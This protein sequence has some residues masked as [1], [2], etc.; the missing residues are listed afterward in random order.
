M[1]LLT[2]LFLAPIIGALVIVFLPK[3]EHKL[4]KSV[5]AVATFVSLALSLYVYFS[6]D[7]QAGGLQFREFIPWIPDFGVNY[8]LGVDGISLPMVLLTALIGFSAV[9]ASWNYEKR[10]KEF[11]ILLLILIAGVMGT[12]VTQDLFIFFLF[13]EVVVIP[14]YIMVIIWGSTKRVTK[15]YA[16]MKLTIYLLIGS[17]FLLGGLIYMLVEAHNLTGGKWVFEISELAKLNFTPEFQRVAFLLMALGFTSLLSMWPFH[18]WSPDGYAGAPT[19]VSMI[20]AG[21]LKKIGGYGLIRIGLFIMPEG[22][23]YWA[24]VIIALAVVNVA[25]AALI[26][27]AQKDLK[28]VVGYSS[29]SHMGYVLLGVASLNIIGIN[30][31]IA[32]MF[33]HGVMSALFFSMIG[34]VY[35]KTHVRTMPDL[36]GLAH[37]IPKIA[38]GFMMAGMASLGLPGLV[39]FVPEFTIFIGV[40]KAAQG[41][42]TVMAGAVI[43]IAG[44][45]ITAL[46]S[47]RLLANTLFGPRRSEYDW[48]PDAKGPELVPL[49]VL[50][51]VLI[52]G[53]LFPFLLMDMVNNGVAPLVAQISDVIGAATKMG[54]NF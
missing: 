6:Y 7:K 24:P 3:D 48:L 15:E 53:G 25:Y 39:S 11:F 27:L 51:S 47:L 34:Y 44:V 8:S 54:G 52:I 18:S 2:A 43:A 29:V 40:W 21:V 14:I 38:T 49:Y 22:A 4:I 17:A 20:H 23:K 9:Y 33:A 42:S 12:F 45:I 30:G 46:Y 1:G 13:Y 32:N 26:A 5:A 50:G 10:P 28:Y 35:D 16:G 36:G 41:N 19:A 37:Q 31:A